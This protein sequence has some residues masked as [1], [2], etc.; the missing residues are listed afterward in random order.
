MPIQV[1]SHEVAARIAAGEVVERPS[2]AV[3]ELVENAVDA[4]ASFVQVEV[5]AGGIEG[6][7]VVDNGHGIPITEMANLFQ[8]HATSKLT[9]A[10]DL[11]SIM[12]M[13]FRGE[14]LY[15][16]AAVAEV[17]L[18]TRTAGEEV[19][20]YVEASNGRALRQE[21]R[22]GPVG[23]TVSV[24]HLFDQVPARKKFLRTPKSELT[25]IHTVMTHY[26]L[27]YPA[28]RFSFVADG[29]TTFSSP[30]NGDM[31]EAVAAV[32]NREVAQALL[33]VEST[34]DAGI[35]VTGLVSTP[36]MHRA[37]RSYIGLY[38]N[39]RPIQSRTLTYAVT[40]AYR[41]MMAGD[42]FPLA[43]LMLS[44]PPEDVDVN[45]HPTKAEVRFRVEGDVF[46]ALQRG[47]R[48]A[49]VAGSPV[50]EMGIAAAGRG[51]SPLMGVPRVPER[52]HS[53][54]GG[55]SSGASPG[56]ASQ[57]PVDRPEPASQ[58]AFPMMDALP[59]LRVLGQSQETY[60]VA[61]GPNGL[62]LIDQ[63]AAHECVVYERLKAAAAKHNPEVQGLLEPVTVELTSFQAET[64]HEY[65]EV[66]AQYGWGLEPFGDRT[67]LLRGVPA[68]LAN[69]GPAKS[70]IELLDGVGDAV[71]F[72]SWEDRIAATIACHGSVRAGLVLSHEEMVE[73]VRLLEKTQQPHT[74]PHGR[75]T[76]L[77]L[78]A[79]NL[80][81]EF[82]RA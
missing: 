48:E 13:G 74:C 14:A 5:T 53:L 3:K 56:Q 1:L 47:V 34:S 8:R 64:V 57:S 36:D 67:Y 69:K 63:H 46:S 41:G 65:G 54:W 6:I 42:R 19:A 60:I 55:F 49:I 78:S 33:A 35:S 58:E 77:H 62:Y 38:V 11:N 28:V 22:G 9:S 39:Q 4:G 50:P 73:M 81:R 20:T 2:S 59:A 17:S 52:S 51:S 45:V 37:N 66:L 43:V 18:L 31:R 82:G 61:E 12:T 10:E 32:Y 24:D 23:T 30:G 76:M 75:P 16:L 79:N 80:E 26:A 27:A 72:S 70:F 29:R 71:E 25:R 15:S 21:P 44:V 68:V 7:R 40:E